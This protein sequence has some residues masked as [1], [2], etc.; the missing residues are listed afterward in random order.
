MCL[1]QAR[2][3]GRRL[4]GQPAEQL[5]ERQVRQG[6]VGEVETV[7]DQST[8]SG[9]DGPRAQLGEQPGLAH[10]GV[11]GDEDRSGSLVGAV[12]SDQGSQPVQLVG[13]ADERAGQAVIWRHIEHH[14]WF[15]RQMQHLP[16]H[17]RDHPVSGP[18]R[19]DA[20]VGWRGGAC[21]VDAGP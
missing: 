10:S 3:E 4:G 17:R 13:S 1:D 21:V 19:H 8:S 6:A 11:A 2:G 18:L 5:G 12:G 7:A 16:R 20:A 14:P 9:L 15:Q